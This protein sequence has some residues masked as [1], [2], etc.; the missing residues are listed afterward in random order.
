MKKALALATIVLFVTAA[1]AGVDLFLTK[2][3]TP[4]EKEPDTFSTAEK[5]FLP[6]YDKWVGNPAH[7]PFTQN[8]G[9]TQTYFLWAEITLPPNIV[10]AQIYGL[11][12][13]GA[14]AN[15]K[16]TLADGLF[17]RHN[18]AAP[19]AYKR[20]D[21][22]GKMNIPGVA[23]AVTARGI[24]SP[25][26]AGDLATDAD[27]KT[28]ALLGA[29]SVQLAADATNPDTDYLGLGIGKLTMAIRVTDDQ[30]NTTDYTGDKAE[31][32]YPDLTVQGQ[33][34]Y[35]PSGGDNHPSFPAV[36]AIPEPASVL[37]LCLGAL[38]RRR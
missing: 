5:N 17:Y 10:F 2:G 15:G 23:V 26:N 27:G 21:S 24:E 8:P 30:G 19:N 9:T 34:A 12:V 25:A 33:N 37:L 7:S 13:G 28:Y 18:K 16:V 38:L 35:D 14:K 22:P 29:L 20:W 32:R 1:S 4:G 6:N 36:R 3:P 31:N 11:D